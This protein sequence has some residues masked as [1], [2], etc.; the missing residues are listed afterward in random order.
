MSNTDK[1]RYHGIT[2]EVQS[3]GRYNRTLCNYGFKGYN[4]ITGEEWN[5]WSVEGFEEWIRNPLSKNETRLNAC[6]DWDERVGI[7]TKALIPDNAID[8]L[9]PHSRVFVDEFFALP[10]PSAQDLAI[11]PFTVETLMKR[12]NYDFLDDKAVESFL[13]YRENS[14]GQHAFTR[15]RDWFPMTRTFNMLA[16]FNDKE[17]G[18]KH[19][20]GT[21]DVINIHLGPDEFLSDSPLYHQAIQ[22]YELI[23]VAAPKSTGKST[24]MRRTAKDFEVVRAITSRALLASANAS[25]FSVQDYK[26]LSADKLTTVKKVSITLNSFTKLAPL[27]KV[28]GENVLMLVDELL[29]TMNYLCIGGVGISGNRKTILHKI[30]VQ[31]ANP[32]TTTVVLDADLSPDLLLLMHR[33]VNDKCVNTWKRSPLRTCV[34]NVTKELEPWPVTFYSVEDTKVSPRNDVLRHLRDGERLQ[35]FVQNKKEIEVIAEGAR[36]EGYKVFEVHGDVDENSNFIQALNRNP[37]DAVEEYEVD[38]L[39]HTSSIDTGLSFDRPWFNRFMAILSTSQ[40]E[41]IEAQQVSQAAARIRQ[42][43]VPRDFYMPPRRHDTIL[44]YP[45][46]GWTANDEAVTRS[47]YELATAMDYASECFKVLNPETEEWEIDK[48]SVAY[49][50]FATLVTHKRRNSERDIYVTLKEQMV[51]DGA[52]ITE[53]ECEV[54]VV[55]INKSSEV[56]DYA[57]S[58]VLKKSDD[59]T[60]FEGMCLSD[61]ISEDDRE[62]LRVYQVYGADALRQV[63]SIYHVLSG[64]FAA[65]SRKRSLRKAINPA[66]SSQVRELI[67]E[68]YKSGLPEDIELA[69][70]LVLV[71]L[72]R[73]P[74]WDLLKGA[75]IGDALKGHKSKDARQ[76]LRQLFTDPTVV[77]AVNKLVDPK[78]KSTDDSQ[79]VSSTIKSFL[80]LNLGRRM[81]KVHFESSYGQKDQ[82]VIP[83]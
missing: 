43:R 81:T 62:R 82:T 25:V 22:E 8:K 13:Y 70:Q 66:H 56:R 77:L 51:W 20:D 53:P 31:M 29:S 23:G 6:K 63:K 61:D 16:N 49:N 44:A 68:K 46:S 12:T 60:R 71:E 34:L 30:L 47:S 79:K 73:N 36:I 33:L 26:Q 55:K 37:M 24:A 11:S 35:V 59:T 27:H 45:H 15:P 78:F 50:I 32:R 4:D 41:F 3:D 39:I 1:T 76:E 69:D 42:Q 17:Y 52:Q 28:K 64:K 21:I 54:E 5:P 19:M 18:H 40:S 38:M 58:L 2:Y 67:E 14:G 7:H 74:L 75:K 65:E 83:T 9:P 48:E 57:K 80:G 10:D 72:I